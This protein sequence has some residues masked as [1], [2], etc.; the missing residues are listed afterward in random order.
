MAQSDKFIGELEDVEAWIQNVYSVLRQE[1]AREIGGVYSQEEM[2]AEEED[3]MSQRSQEV[4]GQSDGGTGVGSPIGDY[5]VTPDLFSSGE[6]GSLG[7]EGIV[8]SPVEVKV[9]D[10]SVDPDLSDDEYSRQMLDRVI[11]PEPEE[12]ERETSVDKKEYDVG[13]SMSANEVSYCA[14]FSGQITSALTFTVFT[15]SCA[16]RKYVPRR[17]LD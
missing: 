9:H 5:A 15:P 8:G 12:G 6:F 7:S 4:A 17:R 14:K 16:M 3:V 11:S 2:D 13:F 10:Q 1:P